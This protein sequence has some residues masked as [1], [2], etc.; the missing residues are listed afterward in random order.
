MGA[1]TGSHYSHWPI[2][3]WGGGALTA[4]PLAL[5]RF[6]CVTCRPTGGQRQAVTLSARFRRLFGKSLIGVSRPRPSF[7]LCRLAQIPLLGTGFSQDILVYFS[8]LLVPCLVSI[9]PSGLN[10]RPLGKSCRRWWCH[11]F[12]LRYIYVVIGIMFAG[13]AGPIFL[14]YTLWLET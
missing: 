10:L 2:P 13:L 12:F 5:L 9:R 1:V 6:L 3:G 4:G 7:W 14:A 8:C 11:V